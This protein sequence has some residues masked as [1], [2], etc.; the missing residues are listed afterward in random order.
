MSKSTRYLTGMVGGLCASTLINSASMMYF[1]APILR[2]SLAP[3]F[4]TALDLAVAFAVAGLI[5]EAER[6]RLPAPPIFRPRAT[7]LGLY[8]A[9]CIGTACGTIVTIGLLARN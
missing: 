6:S 8:L 4:A 1:G 9:C 3:W 5:V 7:F 2:D